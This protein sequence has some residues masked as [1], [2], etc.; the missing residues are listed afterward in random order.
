ML[1]KNVEKK[2]GSQGTTVK[3]D[4]NEFQYTG[5]YLPAFSLQYLFR[6]DVIPLD[7]LIQVY[8]P[9]DSCKSSFAL[10]LA[11]LFIVNNGSCVYI[12]TEH[13]FPGDIAKFYLQDLDESAFALVEAGSPEI[14]QDVIQQSILDS[15]EENAEIREYNK[16]AAP[17]DRIPEACRLVVLDS[18]AAALP[19]DVKK[20]IQTEGHAK[21]KVAVY[22]NAWTS[23]LAKIADDLPRSN[24]IFLVINHERQGIGMFA[25][26]TT[27]GGKMK[28][29]INIIK[30]RFKGGKLTAL[31]DKN[32]KDLTVEMEKNS[33]GFNGGKI[34]LPFE[35]DIRQEFRF[36]FPKAD[37]EFIKKAAGKKE[38]GPIGGKLTVYD[39][40]Y[41][42]EGLDFKQVEAE[43]AMDII[44]DTPEAVEAIREEFGIVAR[45]KLNAGIPQFKD[46]LREQENH[47]SNQV[48]SA[49]KEGSE[50]SKKGEEEKEGEGD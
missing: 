36:D 12:D 24:S 9:P 39:K 4:M 46:Y 29:F 16:N 8:G 17:E 13:K 32:V 28:E 43:E 31:K 45:K 19:E 37:I 34:D 14:A 25:K 35:Y 18:L 21:K 7:R 30:L 41:T 38:L 10:W 49:Y 20:E 27:P 26:R 48:L 42:C 2:Y 11:R 1:Q 44:L 50:I 22:A 47:L 33:C 5:V 6:S 40:K 15:K 23:A 3:L